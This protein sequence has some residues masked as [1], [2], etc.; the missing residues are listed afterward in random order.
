MLSVTG[1]GAVELGKP[2]NLDFPKTIIVPGTGY[3][4]G[5]GGIRSVENRLVFTLVIRPVSVQQ[6]PCFWKFIYGN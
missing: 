3:D 6:G 4:A 2:S 5:R 1:Q